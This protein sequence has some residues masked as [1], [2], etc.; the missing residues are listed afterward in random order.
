MSYSTGEC[1]SES[2]FG[3]MLLHI[4]SEKQLSAQ[5]IARVKNGMVCI[6]PKNM[7]SHLRVFLVLSAHP[8]PMDPAVKR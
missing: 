1:Y 7:F 8:D 4:L 3:N 6:S 2:Q 5:F